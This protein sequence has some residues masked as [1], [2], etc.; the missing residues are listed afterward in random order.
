MH[1]LLLNYL[2]EYTLCAKKIEIQ[3]PNMQGYVCS[4]SVGVF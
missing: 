4:E 2:L 3:M 1:T